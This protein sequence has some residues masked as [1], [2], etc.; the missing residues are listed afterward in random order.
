MGEEKP[1]ELRGELQG[2]LPKA[3]V[4][5][6]KLA[7]SSQVIRGKISPIVSDPDALD[8][9]LHRPTVIQVMVTR[10]G[11]G[12]PRYLLEALGDDETSRERRPEATSRHRA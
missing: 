2:V 7:D 3:H 1:E 12:R 11:N 5:E 9:E 6:F 4:F 8:R 10:V